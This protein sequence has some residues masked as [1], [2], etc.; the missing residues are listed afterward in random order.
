M[1]IGDPN[2]D[3]VVNSIDALLILQFNAGLVGSLANADANHDGMVNS[4]DA[5]LV[6]QFAAGLIPSL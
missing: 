5:A 3:G 6:L 1:L 4:L 2:G